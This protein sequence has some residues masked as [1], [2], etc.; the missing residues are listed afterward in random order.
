MRIPGT[1]HALLGK[2]PRVVVFNLPSGAGQPCGPECLTAEGSISSMLW[3][4]LSI[5]ISS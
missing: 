5:L 4:L 1:S 3:E 2:Q